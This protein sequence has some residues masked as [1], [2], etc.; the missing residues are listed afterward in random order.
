MD[1]FSDF[2]AKLSLFVI[3][4]VSGCDVILGISI[5]GGMTRFHC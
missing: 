4:V 2:G 5:I 1:V 3:A